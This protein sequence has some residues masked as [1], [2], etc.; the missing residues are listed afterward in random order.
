MS[1]LEYAKYGKAEQKP[2]AQV[3]EAQVKEAQEKEASVLDTLGKGSA[4]LTGAVMA[5]GLLKSTY[6]AIRRNQKAKQVFE[7]VSNDPQLA[8][9]DK[10]T[11]LEWYASI[12]HYS[13]TAA[14]DK[15]T[16]KELLKQFATFGKV[17]LQTLKTLAE[18]E[19][20]STSA[21]KNNSAF[22]G[23]DTHLSRANN[24]VNIAKS[25]WGSK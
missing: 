21:K 10:G 2:E 25:L 15:S 16:V 11:L 24:A 13:P 5:G 17:D 12:Y 9:I 4:I 19:D 7:S 23:V 18:M 14:T 6:D 8:K 20:K 3:K 1:M 22:G